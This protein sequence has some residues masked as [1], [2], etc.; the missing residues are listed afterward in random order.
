MEDENNEEL[1]L[2]EARVYEIDYLLSPLIP[3]EAVAERVENS[4]KAVLAAVHSEVVS[5]SSPQRISLAYPI[6]KTVEHKRLIFR[7]AFFGSLRF[8]AAPAA[9]AELVDKF[10]ASPDLIRYLLLE[11]PK[12]ALAD[13]KH[14]RT[15]TKPKRAPRSPSSIASTA[16]PA[17][18]AAEMDK[19][20]DQLLTTE[21][22]VPK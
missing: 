21:A 18:T 10:R 22:Y 4:L 14:L 9:A 15:R 11:V 5:D 13:E 19:E 16:K 12:A 2:G 3:A 20:I 6:R 7:E 8:R 1:S 17:M